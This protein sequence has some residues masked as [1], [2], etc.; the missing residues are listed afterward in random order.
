MPVQLPSVEYKVV[1]NDG[2]VSALSVHPS[3]A[4]EGA[5][6]EML[7][8]MRGGAGA[9]LAEAGSTSAIDVRSVELLGALDLVTLDP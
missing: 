9:D 1:L 7:R 3:E 8:A 2:S 5:L 6:T 4:L